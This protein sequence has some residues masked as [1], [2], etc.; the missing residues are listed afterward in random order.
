[1][2][3]LLRAGGSIA[4]PTE[5]VVASIEEAEREI[6]RDKKWSGDRYPQPGNAVDWMEE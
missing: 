1:M 5:D 6:E 3:I 2:I 4:R